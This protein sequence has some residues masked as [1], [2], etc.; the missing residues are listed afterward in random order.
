MSVK[1]DETAKRLMT[2]PGVGPVTASAIMATIQA[3][4]TPQHCRRRARQQ[5]CT[6]RLELAHQRE[7][8]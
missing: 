4:A 7:R 8:L 5:E 3:A 2:I 1:G 6:D